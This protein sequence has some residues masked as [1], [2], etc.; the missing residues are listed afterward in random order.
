M[1][2]NTK[3]TKTKKS[4]AKKPQKTNLLKQLRS[5]EK[6]AD[7]LRETFEYE[8]AVESY[9]E[10]ALDSLKVFNSGWQ[11]HYCQWDTVGSDRPYHYLGSGKFFVRFGVAMADA[12]VELIRK[13]K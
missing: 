13:Q 5:I 8:E 10:Y 2:K 6:R 1:S 3:T 11:N 9:T 7:G 12:M 4:G